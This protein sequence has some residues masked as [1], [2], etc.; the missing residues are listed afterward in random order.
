LQEKTGRSPDFVEAIARGLE[1]IRGFGDVT[2]PLSL[3]DLAAATGLARPTV[4]RILI[5]LMELG[6]V[7]T[8]GKTFVLTPR[9][10]ELGTAYVASTG[11]WE[12]AERH[13]FELSRATGESCSIAQRDGSDIVYTSRVA[14]PK[15]V[16]FSVTIGTRFPAAQTSLGK[17]LLAALPETELEECLRLPSRAHVEP[18]WHPSAEELRQEL[19][20]VRAQGWALTDQQ[21]GP[22][23]RSVATGIRGGDGHIIAAMNVNAHAAETSLE[24]LTEVYLPLLLKAASDTSAD[25]SRMHEIPSRTLS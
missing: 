8:D 15:L 12:V 7:S 16:T 24:T 19:R 14:V 3:S 25:F 22:A 5:T 21:L 2:R 9:V 4:R 6:Y 18:T 17:V 23:I 10:L 1:V 13:L 20:D 11:L